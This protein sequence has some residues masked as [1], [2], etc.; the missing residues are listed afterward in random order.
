M[1]HPEEDV[2]GRVKARCI[3]SCCV[4]STTLTHDAASVAGDGALGR[5]SSLSICTPL[6]LPLSSTAA[7]RCVCHHKIYHA[8]CGTADLKT[9]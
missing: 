3:Y 4:G 6:P 1:T 9:H 5:L 7:A 2:F 8:L